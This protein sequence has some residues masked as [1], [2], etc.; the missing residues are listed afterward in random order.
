MQIPP[1]I[2]CHSTLYLTVA[3]LTAVTNNAERSPLIFRFSLY[4]VSSVWLYMYIFEVRNVWSGAHLYMS[5]FYIHTCMCVFI[6]RTYVE[7]RKPSAYPFKNQIRQHFRL[8]TITKE[9][10]KLS[11]RRSKS[12]SWKV[13]SYPHY[14]IRLCCQTFKNKQWNVS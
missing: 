1:R 13:L 4:L 2:C 9:H 7:S 8:R 6:Y 14:Y 12:C 10:K 11:K 3:K 5:V